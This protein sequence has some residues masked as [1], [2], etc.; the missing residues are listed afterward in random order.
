MSTRPVPLALSLPRPTAPNYVLALLYVAYVLNFVDRQLL[1]LLLNDIKRD[2]HLADW[3]LGLASGTS[4]AFLYVAA[5]VPVAHLADRTNRVRLLAICV[6]AWSVMTA[7][8]GIVGNFIQLLL[9]RMGVAIGESG[10]QPASLSLIADLFPAEVRSTKLGVYFSAAAIGTMLSYV[11]GGYV[12]AAIGWRWTFLIFAV[13]GVLLAILL[14]LTVR[15][16]QRGLHDGA[17][18]RGAQRSLPG[19]LRDLLRYPLFRRLCLACSLANLA[20]YTLLT[21]APSL[22]LRTYGLST[23]T[24]GVVMGLLGGGVTALSILATGW[25][26]DRLFRINPAAPLYMVAAG[27]LIM[28]VLLP[29]CLFAPGFGLFV[30]TFA[31]CYGVGASYSAPSIAAVQ[32]VVPPDLRAMSSALIFMLGTLAGLGVGPLM[33]GAI[34]DMLVPRFGAESLRYALLIL[35]PLSLA[36]AITYYLAGRNRLRDHAA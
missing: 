28:A 27:M 21:W 2:L 29:V 12:N 3:Q 31:I 6:G 18:P 8:C 20:L 33:V 23:G 17:I 16:P 32:S 24:V 1:T 25:V 34:S 35:S 36:S 15:E 7:A 10:G 22:A 19:A 26:S 11:V 13:P 9:A 30:A 4:F 14:A 5:S